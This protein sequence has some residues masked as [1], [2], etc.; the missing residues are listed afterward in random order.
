MRDEEV[1]SIKLD[2]RN[3]IDATLLGISITLFALVATL[4]PEV[5]GDA[6][7]SVQLSLAIPLFMSA[8]LTRSR[9][10]F[11]KGKNIWD[12]VAFISHAFAYG[13]LINIV[14]LLLSL[15]VL[16]WIVILFFFVNIIS[17][18]TR[19]SIRVYLNP[20]KTRKRVFKELL[21]I[22]IFIFLGL[23]PALKIY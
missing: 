9:T 2:T 21:H 8:L 5:L 13:F 3:L 16:K 15:F 14:G 12:N 7:F 4:K 6:I 10:P 23:L 22:S 11:E 18:L 1:K 20:E 19:S 17:G